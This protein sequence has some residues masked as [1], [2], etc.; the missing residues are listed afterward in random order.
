MKWVTTSRTHSKIFLKSARYD[1]IHS[2]CFFAAAPVSPFLRPKMIV[3]RRVIPLQSFP[4]SF[5]LRVKNITCTYCSRERERETNRKRQRETDRDRQ[6]KKEREMHEDIYNKL[7]QTGFKG[8]YLSERP[9][10]AHTI[11]ITS[12]SILIT[13]L[14]YWLYRLFRISIS[15]VHV[16]DN[17]EIFVLSKSIYIYICLFRYCVN[18]KSL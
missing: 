3:S 7:L 18:M 9:L 13:S 11:L 16:L 10:S 12:S 17:P 4:E 1:L 2:E 6:T 8:K 15:L 14:V 5:F